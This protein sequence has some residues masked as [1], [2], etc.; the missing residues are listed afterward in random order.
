MLAENV[1]ESNQK[2]FEDDIIMSEMPVIIDFYSDDCPPCEALSPVFDKLAEKYAKHMKFVKILRQQNRELADRLGVKSSPTVMF[3]RNGEEV[4]QRLTGYIT[5]PELRRY[6]EN[7]LGDDCPQPERR[8]YECDV[9]VLGA[10]PAGLTAAIYL[11]RAKKKTVLIDEGL[12]GG[13]AATTFHISNY[14]GTN[15]TVRGADLMR[16]M[17]DQAMSFGA[18]IDSLQEVLEIDL[19]KDTKCVK[20]GD[21]DYY[22]RCVI[23]A[24]GAEPRK[25]LAEGERE[26]RGRGV[27]YCAACDGALYQ[28]RRLIVVGGGNSAVE[29]AVFLTKYASHITVV[30]QLDHFQASGVAQDELLKNSGIDVIWESEVRKIQG[31]SVVNSVLIENLKTKETSTVPADGIFVYIGLQPRSE[32]FKELVRLNEWGYVITNEDLSTDVRGVYA[33][34]DIRDKKIRQVATAVG[35]GAIAGMMAEKYLAEIN[36]KPPD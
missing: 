18:A 28:D 3:Y 35:D 23:I 9:L 11:A 2:K 7:V 4:C 19:S 29:E 5:N 14:P 33:A 15:G 22:A 30:H 32:T 10:G 24:T 16:N 12:P 31:D 34:G 6:I 25:L 26:Y 20:T 13:Q 36:V 17:T 1:I 21:T 27:H 8:S